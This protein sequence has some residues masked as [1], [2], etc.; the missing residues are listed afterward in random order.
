MK[1]L[2]DDTLRAL[3]NRQAI[4]A[5][6]DITHML[7]WECIEHRAA[8]LAFTEMSVEMLPSYHPKDVKQVLADT[9]SDAEAEVRA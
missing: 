8:R 2:H 9:M 7:V 3:L 6:D 1:R 5:S 4:S